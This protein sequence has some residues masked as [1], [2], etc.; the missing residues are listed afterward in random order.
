MRG[1]D[2]EMDT[3]KFFLFTTIFNTD[4]RFA[5]LVKDLEWEIL[6]I[7]LHP[8]VIKLASNETFHII[9]TEDYAFLVR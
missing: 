8:R 3:Y 9:N 6:E 5:T 1:V 2:N 7:G 4:V